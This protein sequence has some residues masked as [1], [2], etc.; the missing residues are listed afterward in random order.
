MA[1]NIPMVKSKAFALRI[2]KLYQYLCNEKKEYVISKQVLKS[3]TSIGAN[4]A[5]AECAFSKKDFLS[6][7]YIALK[8][9]S[10]TR[11][12]FELLHESDYISDEQFNSIY[13]DCLELIRLLSASTKTL[14]KELSQ[15]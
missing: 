3:G 4:L 15:Q 10:E 2:V 7:Q 1:V 14:R 8:E 9:C 13:P 5:E 11:F 6:K 12:W